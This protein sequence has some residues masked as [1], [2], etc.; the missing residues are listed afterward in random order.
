M[1]KKIKLN[2]EKVRAILGNMD[3]NE[4]WLASKIG[5]SRQLLSYHMI[6]ESIRGAELIAPILGLEAKDLL[7]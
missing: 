7:T 4:T 5:I 1:T 3:K 6:K 2:T